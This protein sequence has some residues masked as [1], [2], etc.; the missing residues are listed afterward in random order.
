M[1]HEAP[2]PSEEILAIAEKIGDM[3]ELRKKQIKL[4]RELLCTL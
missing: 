1:D 3:E 4:Q 2:K